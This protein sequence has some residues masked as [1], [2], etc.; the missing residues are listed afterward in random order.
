[1]LFPFDYPEEMT[2]SVDWLIGSRETGNR[3][4]FTGLPD[5]FDAR[6]VALCAR[7]SCAKRMIIY[8]GSL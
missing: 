6:K 5:Y 8:C 1:M 3:Y 4:E 7:S 2:R